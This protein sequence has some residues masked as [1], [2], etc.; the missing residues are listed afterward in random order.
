MPASERERPQMNN[1]A[2]EGFGTNQNKDYSLYP[3]MSP[4]PP[5][6]FRF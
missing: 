2:P 5:V 1:D 4:L 3:P 6:H